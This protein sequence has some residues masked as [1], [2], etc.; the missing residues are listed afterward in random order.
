MKRI[1]LHLGACAL[2]AGSAALIS[3][4]QDYT[5]FSNDTAKNVAYTHEFENI[6]GNIDDNQDWDLYGQLAKGVGPITRATG[7]T[8]EKTTV[9]DITVTKAQHDTYITV[10]PELNISGNNYTGS[11]LGQVTQD[12]LSTAREF[13]LAPV[14]WTTSSND[15]IGIYWYVDEED[16]ETTT[17]MGKD[18]K[19]YYVKFFTIF[20]GHKVNLKKYDSA[21]G[22]TVDLTGA[23]SVDMENDGDYLISTPVKV[24][25]PSSIVYYGFYIDNGGTTRY[26]EWNLNPAAPNVEDTD[27][28]KASYTATFNLKNLG[29][30]TTDD[31]QYLCFEDWF[32]TGDFDLNDVVYYA[33]GLSEEN[34]IDNDI[35]TEKAILVCEDLAQFDFDF[36]D[37]ALGLEYKEEDE[38]HWVTITPEE[39]DPYQ[40]KVLDGSTI[41][42]NITAMAAG[43]AYESTITFGNPNAETKTTLGE[44]HSLMNEEGTYTALNHSIINAGSTYGSD[45]QTFTIASE[46]LPEEWDIDTYGTHLSQ[47]FKQGYFQIS[48]NGGLSASAITSSGTISTDK[49][50]NSAPQMMLLPWYFEWPTEGTIISD[51]YTGF[52]DWVSDITQTNWIFD[53]QVEGKVADRGE[54]TKESGSSSSDDTSL[55][56]EIINPTVQTGRTF[57]YDANTTYSNGVYLDIW[58]YDAILASTSTKA[59]L[60]VEYA[61]K[62][63][64]YI[65][66]DDG[67]GNLLVQDS[68]GNN[69]ATTSTYTIS[70]SKLQT[71][72]EAPGGIW[73]FAYGDN[74]NL[75][76]TSASIKFI[77]VTNPEIRHNLTVSQTSLSFVTTDNLTL[78]AASSTGAAITVESS[79]T[80]VATATIADD[81][82]ITV[83]PVANGK[84]TLAVKAAK[85]GDYEANIKQVFITVNQGEL[86]LTLGTTGTCD[87]AFDS[88]S[89]NKANYVIATTNVSDL[90]SW[91][92]GATLTVTTAD[93][94]N[95][96]YKIKD[97]DGN[98]LAS[99]VGGSYENP[100][101]FDLTAEQIAAC[102]TSTG[103][104][105]RIECSYF[106]TIASA[107]LTAK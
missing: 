85:S 98:V 73:I 74:A 72:L 78:T 67:N 91:T 75:K 13:T 104:E 22:L 89:T 71:A 34:I 50:T 83:T 82:T 63:S 70:A 35:I 87:E 32:E 95:A 52:S 33:E 58:G 18:N 57:Y 80:N 92:N 38:Y 3:S 100:K 65:Y 6:F 94:Q 28:H 1:K 48:C 47:L 31:H 106:A 7:D 36:N 20:S 51:A 40:K 105:M 96:V 99:S 97:P 86:E 43:G 60:T 11:N 4:C 69:V 88:W 84:A 16:N 66:V 101:S 10:L 102:K 103:Y 77:G 39:G 45:G 46:N 61:Y 54:F 12:F 64:G 37:V 5:P 2:L 107:V 79:N 15:E 30:S 49:E 19:M 56:T 44:I 29:L 26:S 90:A 41:N 17:M 23:G 14:H 93:N 55:L 53:T 81:G 21:S 42:L 27:D 8:P 76:V 68:F 59:E 24:T 9:S 62:P 25:I